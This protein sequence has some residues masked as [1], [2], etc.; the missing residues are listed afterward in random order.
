[1]ASDWLP[2]LLAANQ[3]LHLKI[4]VSYQCFNP[5]IALVA[6]TPDV[7]PGNGIIAGHRSANELTLKDIVSTYNIII[8]TKSSP[9]NTTTSNPPTHHPTPPHKFH[10]LSFLRIWLTISRYGFRQQPGDNPMMT[11]SNGDIFCVT[12]HLCGKFTGPLWIPLTK[13]SDAELWCF[14]WTGSELTVE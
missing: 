14:L 11:S 7:W 6:L 4:V 2:A 1:M 9:P 3:K 13:A 8:T 10:R 12:G 5:M